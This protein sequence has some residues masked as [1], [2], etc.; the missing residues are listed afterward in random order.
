MKDDIERP[1]TVGAHR[2]AETIRQGMVSWVAARVA[3][4]EAFEKNDWMTLGYRSWDEYCDKEFSAKKLKLTADE[5]LEAA[6]A[7]QDAGM[8]LREIAAATGSSA[9]TISRVLNPSPPKDDLRVSD[10]TKTSQV[11]AAE[12]TQSTSAAESSD[13]IE[14]ARTGRTEAEAQQQPG[15]NASSDDADTSNPPEV[16]GDRYGSDEGDE[17]GEAAFPPAASPDFVDSPN[18][19]VSKTV[20]DALDR[21]VPDADPYAQWRTA[22]LKAVGQVRAV[23]RFKPEEVAECGNDTCLD[24]L[25][26]AADDLNDYLGRV[27]TAWGAALPDNVHQIRRPA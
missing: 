4:E 9:A 22:Y 5:R 19:P 15:P 3:I 23:I 17:S 24:E 12:P 26:R 2:R 27:E 1:D 21:H 13:S 6:R 7:F 8:T 20:A 11:K 10:E 14:P 18:G 25:A 16:P